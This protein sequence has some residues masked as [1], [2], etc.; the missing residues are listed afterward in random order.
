MLFTIRIYGRRVNIIYVRVTRE[1]G[2]V[3]TMKEIYLFFGSN[4]VISA[5]IVWKSITHYW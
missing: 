5:I 4:D 3:Y 1:K 2:F